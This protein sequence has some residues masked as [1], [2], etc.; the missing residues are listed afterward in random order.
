MTLSDCLEKSRNNNSLIIVI[1]ILLVVIIV[2]VMAF[3]AVFL[4][5]KYSRM[6]KKKM[7]NVVSVLH[8]NLQ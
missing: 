8:S 4:N 7:E 1:A 3:V 6:R 2:L 5:K